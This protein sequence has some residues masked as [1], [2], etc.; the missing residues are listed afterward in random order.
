MFNYIAQSWHP[1]SGI[2]MH[3]EVGFLQ[4]LPGTNKV[5]LSLIGNIGVFTVE[6]GD[7]MS[8]DNNTLDLNSNNILLTDATVPTFSPLT[9]VQLSFRIYIGCLVTVNMIANE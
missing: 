5:V 9:K 2:P 4:I 3:R 1:D 7:L 6:Q 8:N